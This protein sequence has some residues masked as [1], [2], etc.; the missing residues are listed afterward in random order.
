MKIGKQFPEET[1]G[2]SNASESSGW[3]WDVADLVVE[4]VSGLLEVVFA[5]LL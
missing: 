3:G 5:L 4:L 2:R 1:C